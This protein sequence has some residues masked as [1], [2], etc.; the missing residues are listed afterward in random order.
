MKIFFS[1][2]VSN[3]HFSFNLQPGS[4]AKIGLSHCPYNWCIFHQATGCFLGLQCHCSLV[5]IG[6]RVILDGQSTNIGRAFNKGRPTCSVVSSRPILEYATQVWDP[7]Q[8]NLIYKLEMV[9][10]REARWVQS[11]YSFQS[12]VTMLDNLNWTTLEQRC[13]A[14]RLSLFHR[15]THQ[16]EPALQ[17][18]NYF[19]QQSTSTRQYHPL[20]LIL[21]AAN[22]TKYQMNYFY[23]TIKEWNNLPS[24]CYDKD[25]VINAHTLASYL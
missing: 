4:L 23:R 1:D 24:L 19:L 5:H 9:Q 25:F 18:P 6:Y 11:D 2:C 7:H 20:R 17:I 10:R 12:S 22:T 3:I 8:Q 16:Q 15:I 21:P 14:S 13:K